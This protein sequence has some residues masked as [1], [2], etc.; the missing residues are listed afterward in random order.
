MPVMGAIAENGGLFY[1]SASSESRILTPIDDI[2]KHRHNLSITFNKL[3]SY[4]PQIRE[5][6]DNQF[7]VTDWTF[8]VDT[9]TSNEIQT[10]AQLCQEMEWGF[11][12]TNVQCHIKPKNQDKATGLF[13]VLHQYFP[14]YSSQ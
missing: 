6:A 1:P 7:R 14:T 12:Y 9:L 13:K 3:Q 11:T 4:F 2:N 5:S 10:I 8:D